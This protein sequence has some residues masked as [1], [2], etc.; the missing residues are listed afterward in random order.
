[1]KTPR[2][3]A[4][5]TNTFVQPF[6]KTTYASNSTNENIT[7]IGRDGVPITYPRNSG[8]SG[9]NTFSIFVHW[10]FNGLDMIGRVINDI[11][12]HT[13]AYPQSRSEMS[14]IVERLKAICAINTNNRNP[15]RVAEIT[16]EYIY[17]AQEITKTGS[18]YCKAT[19]Q[20]M[21]RGGYT[22][23]MFHPESPE[24][25]AFSDYSEVSEAKSV[26]GMFIEV[27]DNDS[28]LHERYVFMGKK[29][30]SIPIKKDHDRASGVYY[31]TAEGSSLGN[32]HV[33]PKYCS[34]AEAETEIGLYPTRE[35]AMTGGNPEML[36]KQTLKELER[37]AEE[38]KLESSRLKEVHKQS[39]MKMANEIS[40]LQHTL[41]VSKIERDREISEREHQLEKLKK[42]NA[43]L[44]E[45]LDAKS[46]V[47]SDYY[48]SRSYDR[49]DSS[50]LIKYIP[51]V[52]VALAAGFAY[53]AKK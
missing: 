47:R 42:D 8:Q 50:E 16:L 24:G 31:S 39:E 49:K 22:S 12:T 25:K 3:V 38:A 28:Q 9:V 20:C 27:I 32:I 52:A 17:N 40:S 11:H 34:F 36:V 21:F 7:V 43:L 15:L 37:K 14:I 13:D 29:V 2:I 1:M 33:T 5:A 51:A 6:I 44:K 23:E 18:L 53:F 35:Q 4:T 45:Q 10:R 30:L 19:D 46:A 48:E 41:S 26:A